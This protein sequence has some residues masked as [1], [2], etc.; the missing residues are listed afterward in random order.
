MANPNPKGARGKPKGL[1]PKTETLEKEQEVVKLRRGGMTWDMIAQR[2][3]Y[4]SPSSARQAFERANLRVIRDDVEALRVLEEDRLDI[5]QTAYWGKAL[6]G[7]LQA[8]QYVL[9]VAESRRKL[10]GLDQPIRQQIEVVTY[11]ANSIE[12]ELARIYS[13]LAQPAHSDKALSLGS[14]A[15][16]PEPTAA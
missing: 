13:T 6:A 7:D 5:L 3:G 1:A 14:S 8:A 16:S 9:K 11:D 10:L 15:S 2:V 12:S 4:A